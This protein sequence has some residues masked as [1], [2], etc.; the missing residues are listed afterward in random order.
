VQEPLPPQKI[1]PPTLHHVGFVVSSIREEIEGFADSV[2]ATWNGQ[3]FEDPLQQVRVAFLQ[4]ASPGE[5]AIELVEPTEEGSRV[6]RF[7]EN[8]GGLHHVCYE[9]ADLEEEL[10]TARSRGGLV[11][12]KPLT[13]VAFNGRRIAW[14]VTRHRLVIEY[15]ER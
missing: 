14:V 12:R 2:A 10:R 9:V 6:S 3:I 5:A 15:L 7:L 11:V 4:P 13:A 1:A 8:G